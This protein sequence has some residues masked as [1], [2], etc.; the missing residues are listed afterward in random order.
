MFAQLYIIYFFFLVSAVVGVPVENLQNQTSSTVSLLGKVIPT[1][2]TCTDPIYRKYK[3]SACV[4]RKTVRVSCESYDLPGTVVDTNFYCADGESCIDMTSNDAICVNENINSVR[5]W[6]N[7]HVDGRVCS[8]PV[9]L[10]K[11]PT[12]YD[13]NPSANEYTELTNNYSFTIKKEN[14]SHYM[15]FCF[16]A[17]TSEEVQAVGALGY[18][19]L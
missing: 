14:F 9:L 6:E 2:P 4:T 1:K 12:K 5:E 10:V 3:S 15:R 18:V 16:V 13:D 19:F 8:E 11:P 7:N 17:G